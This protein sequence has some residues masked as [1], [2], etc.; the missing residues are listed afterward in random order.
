[1]YLLSYCQSPGTASYIVPAAVSHSLPHTLSGEQVTVP[2]K[3]QN[4]ERDV[5][6]F[7][8]LLDNIL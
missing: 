1:M 7:C 8:G 6:P 4:A 2:K 5:N 3:Q